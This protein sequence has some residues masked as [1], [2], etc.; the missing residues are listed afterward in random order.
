MISGSQT[1]TQKE[2]GLTYAESVWNSIWDKIAA[3][4]AAL[5]KD[6]FDKRMQ[7][8][9]NTSLDDLECCK[10]A[11]ERMKAKAAYSKVPVDPS[12][13]EHLETLTRYISA[14]MRKELPESLYERILL[15]R[16]YKHFGFASSDKKDPDEIGSQN[17]FSSSRN[18]AEEILMQKL[19]RKKT[20]FPAW[21]RKVE[22]EKTKAETCAYLLFRLYECDIRGSKAIDE[23][24]YPDEEQRQ[25]ARI[26]LGNIMLVLY[27]AV[28]AAANNLNHRGEFDDYDAFIE[29]QKQKKITLQSAS[30][31]S[32]P[33]SVA[34][35]G[36]LAAPPVPSTPT[37]SSAALSTSENMLAKA[38]GLSC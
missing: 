25:A 21:W 14:A 38:P 3:L 8:G 13:L 24:G 28:P 27:Q 4:E 34:T 20:E 16:G 12:V 31:P 36:L 9:A 15:Y 1:E 33:P 11:C 29:K 22:E 6:A 37:V 23:A 17:H 30:Y 26:T 7:Y 2:S 10:M 5:G 32:L 18:M 19:G 35:Q